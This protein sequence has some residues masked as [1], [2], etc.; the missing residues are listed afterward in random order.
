M[1]MSLL[2]GVWI[3]YR[4]SP[5]E[6]K[7]HSLPETSRAQSLARKTLFYVTVPLAVVSIPVLFLMKAGMGWY[8]LVWALCIMPTGLLI[9]IDDKRIDKND[10]DVSG[11][12]RSLGGISKVI[13]T[14][15]TEA[16]S[17]LDFGSLSSL[18]KPVIRMNNALKFGVRPDLCWQKFVSETG[19]EQV[20]RSVR[21]FW[22]GVAVGG[23]PGQ[24]GNQASMF[25]L[26]VAIL[27]N[28]RKM[29]S[30][31]FYFLCI[32]MHAAM[33][34][35]LVGIYQIMLNFSQLMQS[36]AKG[37]NTARIE[38]ITQ[39]PTFAF[40]SDAGAQL[41]VLNTMVTAML[42][43]L[44]VSNP[45]AIKVVEGGHN[46]KYLFYLSVMLIISGLALILVPDA[47]KGMFS[48]IGAP[49]E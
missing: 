49:P 2:L 9:Y 37:S 7:T 26:K 25:A 29:V 15:I 6:I 16:I 32:A 39:L 10:E 46:Y 35:L 31:G 34:L 19:S 28:K 30:S 38:A 17:R 41:L 48:T 5:K 27:R 1:L 33:A 13:G 47:I 12:I 36:A 42:I 22:D 4:A 40:F 45:A 44:T 21:I 11:F 43:M 3:M 20:N 24:V 18:K 23:D 14:T 8:L